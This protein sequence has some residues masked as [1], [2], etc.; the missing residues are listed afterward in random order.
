MNQ[1]QLVINKKAKH[2]KVHTV[3]SH[4]YAVQGQAKVICGE[5]NQNSGCIGVWTDWEGSLRGGVNVLY[6]DCG[7]DAKVYTFV[8]TN[9]TIHL[10][11]V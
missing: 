1:S 9:W 5:R 11:S 4:L 6:L 10:V 7:V 8:E 3:W 2:Y